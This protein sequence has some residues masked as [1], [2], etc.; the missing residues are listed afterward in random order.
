MN[1]ISIDNPEDGMI[2]ERYPGMYFQYNK[3][4]NSWIRLNGYQSIKL[5]TQVSPGLMPKEDFQKVQRLLTAPPKT[6]LTSDQCDAIFNS[7]VIRL[8]SKDHSVFVEDF[9]DL[10]EGDNVLRE[11]WHIHEDTW[12]FNFRVNLQFLV[13]EM[14]KR[15]NLISERIAGPKG[16]PGDRGDPGI[17]KLDTGP[18]GPPGVDGENAPFNG[19]LTNSSQFRLKDKSKAVVDVTTEQVSQEENYL[20]IHKGVISPDKLCTRKVNAQSP[21]SSWVLVKNKQGVAC[22]PACSKP[23]QCTDET[24]FIDI[25]IIVDSIKDHVNNMIV[26][27]KEERE[28]M[29]KEWLRTLMKVFNEQKKALCCGLEN[30][31]SRK[32][33]QDER[34]Y[35]ETQRIAAAS[36]E[37]QLLISDQEDDEGT[38]QE[39]TK[40]MTYMDRYKGCFVPTEV[41][42]GPEPNPLALL[43]VVYVDESKPNYVESKSGFNSDL[44]AYN[45]AAAGYTQGP[46][47]ILVLQ[48]HLTSNPG[49]YGEITHSSYTPQQDI[50]IVQTQRPAT[51]SEQKSAFN[52]ITGGALPTKVGFILDVSGSMLRYDVEPSFSE[53]KSWVRSQGVS[54]DEREM[55]TERWLH[56]SAE[57]VNG[58]W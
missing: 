24:K 37:F 32:R 42:A 23:E 33:N 1:S 21:K 34:R 31:R 44:S 57:F 39:H 20:V 11:K 30:C 41:E 55:K 27:A 17:D 26:V 8:Y 48:P 50:V 12:G 18:K 51:L 56:W 19:A 36:N 13:E 15:G 10:I 6:S 14:K 7:G 5:A 38:P 4:S 53:F 2:V 47:N 29:A 3:S 58:T 25:D 46:V 43:V 45:A 28:N 40:E 49:T 35:I 16:P 22:V 9:L 52:T 54:T